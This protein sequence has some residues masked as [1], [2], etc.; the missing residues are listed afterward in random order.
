M[1]VW[2]LLQLFF[3]FAIG[4]GVFL[5]AMRL[6]RAPKD[7][8]RLSRGLQILQ[9]KI[10][11]LEDLSDRSDNQVRQLNQ[12]LE[13]KAQDVESQIAHAE[14]KLLDIKATIRK[15]MEAAE[16][17][18][19]QGPDAQSTEKRNAR[20]YIKAARLAHQ[21]KTAEE[22]ATELH[23]PRSEAE[24]IVK[25]NREQLMF[26][27]EQLPSWAQEH[28]G[29]AMSELGQK[30]RAVDK[31]FLVAALPKVEA[32]SPTE[33]STEFDSSGAAGITD[34]EEPIAAPPTVLGPLPVLNSTQH[35]YS[36]DLEEAR[37]LA[38]DARN[39][40]PGTKH[41]IKSGAAGFVRVRKVEFPRIEKPDP[42]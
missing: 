10:A 26:N 8:P 5:L 22:L 23:I 3:D 37:K 4:L 40:L 27:E 32:V 6:A 30:F 12:L 29:Q 31:D 16:I 38:R 17:L 39:A 20:K 9:S 2:T 1:T 28:S 34:E 13:Q 24:F 42:A 21:G 25:V 36:A 19:E 35:P 18:E 14:R 11:I 7:D 33:S 15:C 41:V